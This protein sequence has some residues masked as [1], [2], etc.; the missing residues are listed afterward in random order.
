MPSTSSV[1]FVRVLPLVA[2]T[3]KF[4]LPTSTFPVTASV[5]VSVVAPALRDPAMTVLPL[6]A[7]TVNLL[8]LEAPNTVTS[9]VTS[10]LLSSVV[11]PVTSSVLDSVVAPV[12]VSV[13]PALRLP[14]MTVFPVS[15]ATVNVSE[16]IAPTLKSKTAESVPWVTVLPLVP[17][18]VNLVVPIASD[19]V[20]AATVN[21]ALPMSTSSVTS[22]LPVMVTC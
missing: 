6:L 7:V 1:P 9:P 2:V 20:P 8:T 4:P 18:T 21:F 19:P 22:S 16:L 15:A 11:A 12:A 13:V 17:A 14:A 5:L 10:S 3:A